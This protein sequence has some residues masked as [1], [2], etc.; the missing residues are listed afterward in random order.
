MTSPFRKVIS[1]LSAIDF[2]AEDKTQALE[3]IQQVLGQILQWL[4]TSR[5]TENILTTD[6]GVAQTTAESG[7]A[8]AATAQATADGASE[9]TIQH[10]H[11]SPTDGG[12]VAHGHLLNIGTFDHATIDLHLLSANEHGATGAVVG[13]TNAQTLT[14][15]TLTLPTIA[16]L[17]NAAHD[18]SNAAGGGAISHA[19]L[20]FA[21]SNPHADI[22]D[23][24]AGTTE[25]GATGVVVGTTNAQTLTNKTL[26]TPT[27][28]SFAN[29][30]H[31]HADDAGGG[32]LY[33]EL[34]DTLDI[35]AHDSGTFTVVK[36]AAT[37]GGAMGLNDA[38]RTVWA[39][40]RNVDTSFA[41]VIRFGFYPQFDVSG[42]QGAKFS[43][44]TIAAGEN[45]GVRA[46]LTESF[47]TE[48][49]LENILRNR[50]QTIEWVLDATKT[51]ITG[52]P[53][54]VSF[55]VIRIATVILTELSTEPA[56]FTMSIR[57]R[58]KLAA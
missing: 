38:F 32:A 14:N 44:D 56:A 37:L 58:V 46:P 24:L 7:V 52:S 21:G 26:T 3:T 50:S 51:L 15:K 54:T 35:F 22:D 8:A 10:D 34:T 13:T 20:T 45:A 39:I 36:D 19:D 6:T 49:D 48:V 57:Y 17:T 53:K 30:T 28:G 47:S 29:A 1:N 9:T 18:H 41:P 23:H 12:P 4:E 2:R 31:D 40:P 25:H 42:T 43:L 33:V 55:R 27:I 16:D 5:N 11:N